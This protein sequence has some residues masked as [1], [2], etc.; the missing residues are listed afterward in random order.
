MT[1]FRLVEWHLR[2]SNARNQAITCNVV[3]KKV[4]CGN[5]DW[6]SLAGKIRERYDDPKWL[7]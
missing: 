4:P 6:P 2:V 1:A 7:R 5:N 3:G